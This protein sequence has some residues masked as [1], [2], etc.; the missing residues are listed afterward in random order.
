MVFIVA[1]EYKND[2]CV[3]HLSVTMTWSNYL[4]TIWYDHKHLASYSGPDKLYK[5]VKEEGKFKIGQTRIK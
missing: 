4:H 5:I 3:I 2:Y 1:I